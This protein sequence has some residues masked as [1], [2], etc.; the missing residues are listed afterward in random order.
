MHSSHSGAKRMTINDDT[1]AGIPSGT[2][3][4]RKFYVAFV[5]VPR[6]TLVAFA[7]FV[8][9]L[10][11]AAD[12]GD[13]SRQID[14]TWAVV[15]EPG[16]PIRASC[17]VEFTATQPYGDPGRFDYVVVVG[18]LLREGQQVPREAIS[19]LQRADAA[20][21]PLIGLCTGS[22]VLARAGLMT[23]YRACV[24]WLHRAEF[25]RDFPQVKMLSDQIFVIDRD[26]MTCAGGLS[27]AHLAAYLIERHLGRSR[28]VKSLRILIED[29]PLPGQTAQPPTTRDI[30]IQDQLVKRAALL[31]EQTID[32]PMSVQS[33]AKRLAVSVRQLE[34]RFLKAEGLSPRDFALQLRLSHARWLIEHT[35]RPMTSIALESG[36]NDAS[37]FARCFRRTQ[38]ATPTSIRTLFYLKRKVRDEQARTNPRSGAPPPKKA[39][40][41]RGTYASKRPK[42]RGTGE[43]TV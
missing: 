31:I 18:G 24:S 29:M 38:G 6:F 33:L 11:L 16:S 39:K 14:C 19:F 26:R 25:A 3:P 20:R 34:R 2:V 40:S 12:E 13:R 28:A 23:G 10:R 37:H 1:P 43:T 32:T 41:N 5:L 4:K 27:V 17:G 30:A 7:G 9:A 15:G 8:D 35:A 21:K 22:F 36:F 42:V